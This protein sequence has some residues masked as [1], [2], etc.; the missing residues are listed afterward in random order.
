MILLRTTVVGQAI[1]KQFK[2][3]AITTEPP[4]G[5]PIEKA[6]IG[7]QVLRRKVLGHRERH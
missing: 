3:G 7:C 5:T 4:R 2:E 1:V 6:G